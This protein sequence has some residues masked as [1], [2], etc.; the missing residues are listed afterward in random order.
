MSTAKFNICVFNP[1]MSVETK[2]MGSG[3]TSRHYSRNASCYMK[4][5]ICVKVFQGYHKYIQK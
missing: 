4:R 3:K 1:E 5:R 2:V